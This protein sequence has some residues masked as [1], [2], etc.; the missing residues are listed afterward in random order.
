MNSAIVALD[1]LGAMT[2]RAFLKSC[3][4]IPRMAEVSYKL[5]NCSVVIS[6]IGAMAASLTKAFKSA[7]E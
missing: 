2:L 4:L 7:H 6:R 1:T 3:K 5:I